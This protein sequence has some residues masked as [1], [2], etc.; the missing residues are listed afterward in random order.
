MPT[1]DRDLERGTADARKP[2]RKSQAQRPATRGQATQIDFLNAIVILMFSLAAFFG[3]SM[4]ILDI[5]DSGG[6][7]DDIS[8]TRSADRLADD[9]FLNN[10]TDN[11]ADRACTQAFFSMDSNTKCDVP[12]GTNETKYVHDT[13]GVSYD[14]E[15]NI[16]LTSGGTPVTLSDPST[17]ATTT[18]RMGERI[19]ESTGIARY[20]RYVAYPDPA[21]PGEYNYYTLYIT[22]WED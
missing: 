7:A 15:I 6:P 10:T 4:I 8:S 5:H 12:G 22:M 20:H 16:T 3:F 14:Y 1:T 21:S 19:P 18:A 9:V 2:R 11:I 13:L 17:G